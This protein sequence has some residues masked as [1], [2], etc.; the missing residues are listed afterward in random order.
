[1]NKNQIIQK[2]SINLFFRNLSI[3]FNVNSA[4]IFWFNFLNFNRILMTGRSCFVNSIKLI[5][6]KAILRKLLKLCIYLNGNK[7]CLPI[8]YLLESNKILPIKLRVQSKKI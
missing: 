5:L 6:V 1:M 8:L 3:A 4:G 2:L 7:H